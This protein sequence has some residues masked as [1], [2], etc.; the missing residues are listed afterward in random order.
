LSE[1]VDLNALREEVRNWLVENA[2]RDWRAE[3]QE[4]GQDDFVRAQRAWFES[5]VKGGYAVP[6]WPLGWPGGGRTLAEQ[7]V[8]YEEL[9]RADCPRL[10][11]TFVSTYHAASTL[12]K[13]GTEEQKVRYVPGILNGELWCQGFSEPNAGSDLAS[14][15]TRAELRGD[16][17][18]V[19]GQKVWSTLA[20]HADWCLLLVRT[21]TGKV[22][23]EGITF[24]LM[25]MRSKGVTVRPIK[26]IYGDSDFCEIFLDDVEIGIENRVGEEGRGWMIAQET[27]SSERGLTLMELSYRMRH[28]LWRISQL[29]IDRGRQSDAGVLRKFGRLV[30]R[31]QSACAVADDFLARRIDGTEEV[32][33]ASIV[34]NTYSSVLRDYAWFGVRLGGLESQYRSPV[35]LGDLNTGNWMADFMHSYAWSIAG[36]AEEIQ[37]NIVAE[38]ILQM[39]R[40]PKTWT[41]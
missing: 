17:Y 16:K 35:T 20:H 4:R 33:D 3:Y 6:H 19:N 18:I 40:E 12:F 21:S 28:G 32:G 10:L 41:L 15:R 24:L 30:T 22:K 9:A 36:G 29:I 31:V 13:C 38:R 25:S 23:Q 8:I 11:L 39:Q 14:I 1:D 2:P 7:R 26:Q 37:R 5:L 27:L 34:K